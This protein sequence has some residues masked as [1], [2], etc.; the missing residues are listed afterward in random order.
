MRTKI[1]SFSDT[2]RDSKVELKDHGNHN[3]LLYT[4][5]I[6]TGS[7]IDGEDM[8]EQKR[9]KEQEKVKTNKNFDIVYGIND[10]PPWY[11]CIFFGFQQYLTAF[12]SNF[13]PP[14]II[15]AALCMSTDVISVSELMGTS[16][17]ISGLST[18]LMTTFGCRFQ[19]HQQSTGNRK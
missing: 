1:V 8:A 15:S 2:E 19:E 7:S 16:F 4:L 11:L 6:P 17:F 3:R 10:V 5:Q 13:T 14:L 12:G 9:Q 18:I